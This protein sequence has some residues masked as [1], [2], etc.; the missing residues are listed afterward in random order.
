MLRNASKG[1][2]LLE[3][4]IVLLIVGLMLGS[5]LMPLTHQMENTKRKQTKET[6]QL[7]H[8]AL[9][10][11]AISNGR[12]PCPDSDGD[13][14]ENSPCANTEGDLPW[15]TLGIGREDAWHNRFRY[16]ADNAFAT[17]I[18]DPPDTT[19]GL[20]VTDLSGSA[21][22]SADPHAPVAIIFSCGNDGLPNGENDAN[23][24]INNPT[25]EN[26]GAGNTTY[27]QD[28]YADNSFDDLLIWISK[29]TLLNRVVAAGQWP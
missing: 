24:A 6:L 26:P 19:S 12:L 2:T 4:A 21:L 7:V 10:G 20:S 29:H 15:T 8:D 11:F 25:C 23:G 14:V 18:P 3:M 28:I 22:T 1:F 27:V 13:G 5:L 16:R 17:T 9:L